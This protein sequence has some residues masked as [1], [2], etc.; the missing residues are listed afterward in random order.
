MVRGQEPFKGCNL[1]Y[2]VNDKRLASEL[3]KCV[4]VEGIEVA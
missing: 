3:G 4:P 1:R 2:K